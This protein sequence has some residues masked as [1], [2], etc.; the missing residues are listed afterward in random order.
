M[1]RLTVDT[2]KGY[3]R[4]E[5]FEVPQQTEQSLALVPRNLRQRAIN[6]RQ[7][8]ANEETIERGSIFDTC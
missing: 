7:Q 1:D 4:P 5:K 3:V 8:H 6:I 2:H